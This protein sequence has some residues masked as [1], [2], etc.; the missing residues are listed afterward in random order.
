MRWL[1]HRSVTA[2]SAASLVRPYVFTGLQASHSVHIALLPS[3]TCTVKFQ[4]ISPRP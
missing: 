3:Y 1:G 4:A 2:L